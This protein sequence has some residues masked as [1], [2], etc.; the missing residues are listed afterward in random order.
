M[1]TTTNP[2]IAD[3]PSRRAD[4]VIATGAGFLYHNHIQNGVLG[5]FDVELTKRL[6]AHAGKACAIVTVPWPSIAPA[7]YARFAWKRNPKNYPG[8]G[9]QHR[10]FQCAVGLFNT[11]PQ[12]QS[13]AFTHPYTDGT[14]LEAGFLVVDRVASTF[15]AD[16]ADRIVGLLGGW[17][18]SAYFRVHVGSM[19]R[20]ARVTEFAEEA[21]MLEALSSDAV[22]AV[23]IDTVLGG[24][25]VSSGNGYQLVHARAGWSPGMAYGCHPAYGNA[26][27]ALNRGLEAFVQTSEY[28]ALC[29]RFS[30]V[31]CACTGMPRLDPPVVASHQGKVLCCAWGREWGWSGGQ[32]VP[33]INDLTKYLIPGTMSCLCARNSKT[34][35]S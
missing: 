10:W 21:Q 27:G 1:K 24:A 3:H 16:A 33:D 15:P 35:K 7:D 25:F 14:T 5:G 17:G 32:R 18:P 8:E 30:S 19:F 20:P 26:V 6:C 9:Y 31:E 13:I 12:Q 11:V 2:E 29:N 22:D 28:T 23:F 4:V 34:Q